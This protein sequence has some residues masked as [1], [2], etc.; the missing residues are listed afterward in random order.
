[1]KAL[2][3]Y[4]LLLILL[5]FF[6]S[7]NYAQ[8]SCKKEYRVINKQKKIIKKKSTAIAKEWL[9]LNATIKNLPSNL[10][11][12]KI[13]FLAETKEEPKWFSIDSLVCLETTPT[14]IEKAKEL[15][16]KR[17]LVVY[18]IRTTFTYENNANPLIKSV[19]NFEFNFN[20]DLIRAVIRQ[21]EM[22]PFSET[23]YR[24]EAK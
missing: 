17:N 1:M 5:S 21:K 4:L 10:K 2:A 18:D 22:S 6:T 20:G 16:I 8:Y 14:D 24:K 11:L 19:L 9:K 13:K 3:K 23:P 15:L 7:N 12:S